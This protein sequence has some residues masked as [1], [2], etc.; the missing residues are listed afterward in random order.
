MRCLKMNAWCTPPVS[1]MLALHWSLLKESEIP[2]FV[3][4]VPFHC[5]CIT[6]LLIRGLWELLHILIIILIQGKFFCIYLF[7]TVSATIDSPA[8]LYIKSL[9]ATLLLV[10]F[11]KAFNLWGVEHLCCFYL[12]SLVGVVMVV[13]FGF[14]YLTPS[15][16]LL[17]TF[18][19]LALFMEGCKRI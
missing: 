7:P 2:P 17:T 18:N 3:G 11:S 13:D 19:L 15:F 8:T 4:M 12:F 6:P 5:T 9:K 10:D 16:L 14:K 1:K